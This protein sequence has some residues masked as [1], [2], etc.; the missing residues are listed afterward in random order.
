MEDDKRKRRLVFALLS[1][2]LFGVYFLSVIILD[3]INSF[4]AFY[5]IISFLGLI[6]SLK[7]YS[8]L[9]NEKKERN[10][11]LLVGVV[12]AGGAIFI[13]LL[14]AVLASPFPKQR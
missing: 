4:T 10:S 11:P 1:I 9:K 2:I 13:L 14:I 12:V 8:D 3:G 7:N 5:L 6:Y